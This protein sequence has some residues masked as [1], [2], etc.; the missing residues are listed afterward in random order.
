[1]PS[2]FAGNVGIN[3]N[4]IVI[5]NLHVAVF[6]LLAGVTLSSAVCAVIEISIMR[7]KHL[8]ASL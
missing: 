1:M 3:L 4:Y 8:E 7:R 6:F 5:H 2:R